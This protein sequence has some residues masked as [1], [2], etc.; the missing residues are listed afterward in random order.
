MALCNATFVLLEWDL[1]YLTVM[2]FIREGSTKL[3]T[4]IYMY[5]PAMRKECGIK[6]VMIK[7]LITVIPYIIMLLTEI[8]YPPDVK[9]L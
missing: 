8:L 7:P 3:M 4:S 9:C 5:I 2:I 6:R 1:G